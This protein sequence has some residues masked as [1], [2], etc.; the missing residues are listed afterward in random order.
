MFCRGAGTWSR[1]ARR[2]APILLNLSFSGTKRSSPMN[3]CTR[4]HG[5]CSRQ[6]CCVS[7]RY[8]PSG[9]E[10]PVRQTAA[11]S[12]RVTRAI[13]RRAAVSANAAASVTTTICGWAFTFMANS[14]D[15]PPAASVAREQFVC[16]L[17]AIAAGA[18]ARKALAFFFAP[19]IK[20]R[21]HDAPAGFNAVGPG[22]KD[23]I[24]DHTVINQSFVAGAW[25]GFEIIFI[26]ECHAHAADGDRRPRNF[27][28]KFE[29]DAFVR[30]NSDDQ[31]VFG[32]SINRRIAKHGDRGLLEFYCN[33]GLLAAERL[34]GP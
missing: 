12:P 4:S 20:E 5:T 22:I 14:S 7:K 10:P 28:V 9:F 16:F 25:R 3:Q 32:K 34:A 27:C 15:W 6:G 13:S 2:A 23:R 24:A 33:L 18:I 21:L 17:R 19:G 26:P 29:T 8:S 11:R 31:E 30:L 1:N